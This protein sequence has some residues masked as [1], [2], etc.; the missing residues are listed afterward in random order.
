M[1]YYILQNQK[2][3]SIKLGN[4][5]SD[6]GATSKIFNLEG[7]NNFVFKEYKEKKLA[8]SSENKVDYFID[9]PPDK[10]LK[11]IKLSNFEMH[12][13]AWPKQKVFDKKNNFA[14]FIMPKIRLD[15]AWDE[16]NEIQ[17]HGWTKV[18]YDFG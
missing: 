8:L 15:E 16:W 5:L 1:N 7:T 11:P 14:G 2:K 13:L 6:A 12:Q 18:S 3:A 17:E 9:N 4:I 10:S